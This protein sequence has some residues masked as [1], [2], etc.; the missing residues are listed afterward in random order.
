MVY[1]IQMRL[2]FRNVARR[3]AVA[4]NIAVKF[5]APQYGQPIIEPITIR[6]TGD[7]GLL[8]ESRFINQADRDALWTDLDN[9]FGTGVNGPV[10]GSRAWQHECPHDEG[11]G[12]CTVSVERVW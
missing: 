2:G 9:T 12:V 5:T 10:V 6:E 4:S 8:I 11:A 1:A 3:D 7:P